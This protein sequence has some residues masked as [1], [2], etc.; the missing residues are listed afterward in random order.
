ME[1]G[2]M[3]ELLLTFHEPMITTAYLESKPDVRVPV[4]A[5][6]A[7]A[8]AGHDLTSYIIQYDAE[9]KEYIIA[10]GDMVY[11]KASASM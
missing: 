4:K 5:P 11:Q 8:R 2:R 1:L 6:T 10:S 7:F 3:I 9:R